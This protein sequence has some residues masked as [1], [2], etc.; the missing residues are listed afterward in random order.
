MFVMFVLKTCA[1]YD[2][3]MHYK[4]RR[5]VFQMFSAV[6]KNSFHSNGAK[7]IEIKHKTLL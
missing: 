6:S 4:C 5:R 2:A 7:I 3:N 1:L